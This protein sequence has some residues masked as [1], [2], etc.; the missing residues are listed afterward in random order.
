[1]RHWPDSDSARSL[2]RVGPLKF[3][4]DH[5]GEARFF[6]RYLNGDVDICV[7]GRA[8][9]C[10]A[11]P[12]YFYAILR[13]FSAPGYKVRDGGVWA[14][15][16]SRRLRLIGAN[17]NLLAHASGSCDDQ[18]QAVFVADVEVV[19]D[20][21]KIVLGTRLDVWLG[22]TD[23]FLGGGADPPYVSAI[24]SLYEFLRLPTNGELMVVEWPMPILSGERGDEMVEYGSQMVNNLASEH[25][26]PQGNLHAATRFNH[27]LSSLV[28]EVTDN[29]VLV[30]VVPNE[31]IYLRVE[32]ADV[33]VGP[34]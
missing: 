12:R 22:V 6:E 5:F 4:R 33:L 14:Y 24:N 19:Q 16:Q 7:K 34:L 3:G 18:E 32:V 21:E 23:Q 1:M 20:G 2:G 8:W 15:P 28:L 31:G 13:K 26:E 25:G 27:I 17:A 11:D 29:A 30:S 9:F 10:E